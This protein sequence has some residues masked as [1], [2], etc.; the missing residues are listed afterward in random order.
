MQ[1]QPQD[2][3]EQLMNRAIIV[4][5][6]EKDGQAQMNRDVQME[7]PVHLDHILIEK[8]GK[9]LVKAVYGKDKVGQYNGVT[10]MTYGA[11]KYSI[12]KEN[13]KD[14]GEMLIKF[15]EEYK[16]AEAVL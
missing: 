7:E 14:G 5:E 15:I 3:G 9:D 6:E 12:S 13:S 10:M 1:P 8:L 2:A 16:K 4:E 11:N